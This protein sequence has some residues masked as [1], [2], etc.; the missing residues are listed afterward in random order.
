M[1]SR[2]HNHEIYAAALQGIIEGGEDGGEEEELGEGTVIEVLFVMSGHGPINCKFVAAYEKEQIIRVARGFQMIESHIQA[3]IISGRHR[4][5][6]EADRV[7]VQPEGL[8]WCRECPAS[9]NHKGT[10]ALDLREDG[11]LDKDEAWFCDMLSDHDQHS[12][13]RNRW[14]CQRQFADLLFSQRRARAW[15]VA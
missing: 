14:T 3:G 10:E 5:L 9:E 2:E 12:A 7:Q 8:T 15:R 4:G 6:E 13:W 1:A 11:L